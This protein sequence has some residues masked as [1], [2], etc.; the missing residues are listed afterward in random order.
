MSKP[1]PP[2]ER[3]KREAPEM[4]SKERLGEPGPR[5]SL[6]LV[7]KNDI[8]ASSFIPKS[9]LDSTAAGETQEPASQRQSSRL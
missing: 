7:C 6:G 5:G 3:R 8:C 2:V 4:L 1:T 9:H